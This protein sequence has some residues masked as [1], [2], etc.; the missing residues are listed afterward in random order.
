VDKWLKLQPKLFHSQEGMMNPKKWLMVFINLFGG[1]AVLG[2][3]IQGFLTHPG[4]A[5]VLWGG[6]PQAIRP[7]YT[8]GMFLAAAGY[9]AFT[10]FI[11]FRLNP[12]DTRVFSRFG[13]GTFNA[14]YAAILIPSAL[15]MPL[16]FLAVGNSSLTLLWMVRIVLAVVG[17]ASLGL[18]FTLLTVQPRRPSWAHK[19]AIIGC[20]FFCIQTVLLDAIIWGSLFR[21]F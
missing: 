17:L 10:Y 14:F 20:A 3:Y 19:L 5:E 11:L 16:T 18:L 12:G 21:P 4:A 9:F 13:F 15:W 7:F 2:S 6:V 1:V 8:A